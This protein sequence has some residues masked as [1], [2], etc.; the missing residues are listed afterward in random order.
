MVGSNL[1]SHTSDLDN[2]TLKYEINK[3][4]NPITLSIYSWNV[5]G[6]KDKPFIYMYIH[7]W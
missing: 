2:L 1:D 5:N 4:D 3:K 7:E 6:L